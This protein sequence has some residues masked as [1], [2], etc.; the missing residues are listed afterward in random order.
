MS[1]C[2]YWGSIVI[3]AL[4]TIGYLVYKDKSLGHASQLVPCVLMWIAIAQIHTHEYSPYHLLWL[5]PLSLVIG[6]V[7]G[8]VV[9]IILH[10]YITPTI[11]KSAAAIS[12]LF[13]EKNMW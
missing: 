6:S 1:S 4:W 13:D 12:E 5:M 9:I 2:I 10:K 8:L 11:N 7:V 3:A